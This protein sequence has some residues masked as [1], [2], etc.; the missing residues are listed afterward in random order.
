M[1]QILWVEASLIRF[2]S[3]IQSEK[4]IHIITGLNLPLPIGLAQ[5]LIQMFQ[6]MNDRK[7]NSD[8]KRRNC[9]I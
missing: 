9:E 4:K 7:Y 6:Q 5:D 1:L 2:P 8:G 3:Y